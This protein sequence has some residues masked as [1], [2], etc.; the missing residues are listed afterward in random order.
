VW[1]ALCILDVDARPLGIRIQFLD[2]ADIDL[3]PVGNGFARLA[4]TNDKVPY[5]IMIDEEVVID[6][7]C[8]DQRDFDQS[9][10]AWTIEFDWVPAIPREIFACSG[11][12]LATIVKMKLFFCREITGL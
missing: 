8:E 6:F 1:P 12:D 7:R 11:D 4:V 5:V 10:L 9:I 2:V 3:K